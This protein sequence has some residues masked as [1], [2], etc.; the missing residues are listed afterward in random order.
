[1]LVTA[2]QAAMI[3]SFLLVFLAAVQDKRNR[4]VSNWFPVLLLSVF[5][6]SRAALVIAGKDNL[7]DSVLI[8]LALAIA[9]LIVLLAITVA[10]EGLKGKEMFGGGD[11]KII[12]ST[13][14]IL[15]IEGLLFSLLVAFSAVLL[16]FFIQKN[17]SNM[18]SDTTFP[19]VPFFALGFAACTIIS[20]L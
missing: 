18:I 17:R 3:I 1:M 10:L 4:E 2:E 9:A 6:I 15:G 8:P 13:T 5:L 19:F 14:P 20:F 7:T 11:I 12:A 16:Y